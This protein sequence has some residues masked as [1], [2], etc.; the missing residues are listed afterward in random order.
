MLFTS[1]E[2]HVWIRVVEILLKHGASIETTT[3]SGLNLFVIYLTRNKSTKTRIFLIPSHP[4][5]KKWSR[6]KCEGQGEYLSMFY[7]KVCPERIMTQGFSMIQERFNLQPILFKGKQ[8][9]N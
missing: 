5:G 4:S 3:E 6:C 8:G 2:V 7:L 1:Q 9:K